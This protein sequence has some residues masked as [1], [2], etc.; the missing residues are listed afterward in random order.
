M[1]SENNSQANVFNVAHHINSPKM[2]SPSRRWGGTHDRSKVTLPDISPQW[3]FEKNI[4]RSFTCWCYVDIFVS[5]EL[6]F[7]HHGQNN[8]GLEFLRKLSELQIIRIFIV[9]WWDKV[10]PNGYIGI[11]KLLWQSLL[12]CFFYLYE[13]GEYILKSLSEIIFLL[14]WHSSSSWHNSEDIYHFP[15]VES[16]TS[17][18]HTQPVLSRIHS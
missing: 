1:L 3:M 9:R 7:Y 5:N 13:T 8:M 14:R 17:S 15:I 10:A 2:P 4:N 18:M 12:F 6:F 11:F 16:N